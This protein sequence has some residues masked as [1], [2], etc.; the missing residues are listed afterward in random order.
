MI[1][2]DSQLPSLLSLNLPII[3]R[4]K[5]RSYLL[6][7]PAT[8]KWHSTSNPESPVSEA[9]DFIKYRQRHN[10]ADDSRRLKVQPLEYKNLLARLEELPELK[11]FVNNKLRYITIR[12]AVS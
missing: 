3:H 10:S 12:I 8:D 7:P 4:R 11:E 6:T 1:R 2:R 5:G 9:L